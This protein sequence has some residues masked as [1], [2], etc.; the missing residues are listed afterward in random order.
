MFWVFHCCCREKLQLERDKAQQE[1]DIKIRQSEVLVL[2]KELDSLNGTLTQL[3][4]Q[5]KEAQKRLDEL[6]DKVGGSFF[7]TFKSINKYLAYAS[8]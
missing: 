3:D 7:L 4:S 5:K 2:Q 8:Q 6:D 1:A